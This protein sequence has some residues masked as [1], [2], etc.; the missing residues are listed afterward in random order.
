[1]CFFPEG[2]PGAQRAERRQGGDE[3]SRRESL[4]RRGLFGSRTGVGLHGLKLW[5]EGVGQQRRCLHLSATV[6][7]AERPAAVLT[8]VR[9]QARR[10]VLRCLRKWQ[11]KYELEPTQRCPPTK[12]MPWIA[13]VDIYFAGGTGVEVGAGS[14]IIAWIRLPSAVGVVW[15]AVRSI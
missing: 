8:P 7:G 11:G 3:Q 1:M 15:T 12:M 9:T 2:E 4:P 13:C 6:R 14:R 10:G 5:R